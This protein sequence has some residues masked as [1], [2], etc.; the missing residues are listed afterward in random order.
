M[1]YFQQFGWALGCPVGTAHGRSPK[2]HLS[3]RTSSSAAITL[4]SKVPQSILY[5]VDPNSPPKAGITHTWICRDRVCRVPLFRDR[6]PI[7][8]CK[9][10]VRYP[11]GNSPAAK[12]IDKV[13]RLTAGDGDCLAQGSSERAL[14][15]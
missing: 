7:K 9:P 10:H 13:T 14:G 8:V 1:G 15:S 6:T 3:C 5:P 2:R 11:S 4:P 12:A